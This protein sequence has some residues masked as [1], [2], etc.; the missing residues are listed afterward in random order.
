MTKLNCENVCLAAMALMDGA[1]AAL[2]TAEIEQHL[3]NCPGCR[4]EV[5]GLQALSGL[6]EAQERR[7]HPADVWLVVG[8]QLARRK[9]PKASMPRAFVFLG[10]LLVGYKLVDLIPQTELG[11]A[12]KLVP[13]ALVIAV[14]S[15][16]RENPFKVNAGLRLEGE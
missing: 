9:P 7:Q 3:A 8:A 10:L 12:F 14:F 1:R 11:L 15:Y 2:S 13:L 4:A 16:L 5:E 6:M